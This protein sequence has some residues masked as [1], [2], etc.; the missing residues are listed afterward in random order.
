M[1]KRIKVSSKRLEQLR[2]TIKPLRRLDP[3]DVAKA[4]GAELVEEGVPKSLLP[5][6][7][8]AGPKSVQAMGRLKS[9][10]GSRVVP[11][12]PREFGEIITLEGGI[13]PPPEGRG[14]PAAI[15]MSR[16]SERIGK[17]LPDPFG[18]RP[19]AHHRR[20]GPAG[21]TK[22]QAYKPWLPGHPQ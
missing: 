14:Y 7:L 1:G 5:A 6:R 9:R 13:P 10:G 22:Y 8:C 2:V 11:G 16:P 15:S 4:L 17:E 18:Y 19:E 20:H 21:Y 12:R 3:Q